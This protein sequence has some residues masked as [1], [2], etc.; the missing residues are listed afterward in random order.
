MTA[1][2]FVGAKA[3]FAILAAIIIALLGPFAMGQIRDICAQHNVAVAA[4]VRPFLA[5]PILVS[6]ICLPAMVA[7][8]WA[9]ADRNRRW[10]ALIIS[11]VSLLGAVGI[12]LIALVS[13]LKPLYESSP[14]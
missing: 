2:L 10:I 9:L 5:T 7:G 4:I 12:V 11:T 1:A 8:V 3:I 13:A 14:L 6:V